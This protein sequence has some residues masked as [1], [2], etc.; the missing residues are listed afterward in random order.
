VR[1]AALRG[2]EGIAPR[3]KRLRRHYGVVLCHPF[4]EGVDPES[5]SFISPWDN[6]KRCKNTMHW[7][8]SK[9]CYLIDH[10]VMFHIRSST[11]A[12]QTWLGRRDY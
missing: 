9:V 12:N 2:L 10:V 7:F 8:I 5:N 6:T 1:G 4:R 3:V 11:L